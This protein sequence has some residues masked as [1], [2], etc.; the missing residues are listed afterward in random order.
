MTDLFSWTDIILTIS[1]ISISVG[2]SWLLKFILKK[3]RRPN[4]K[5][6]GF[7][8]LNTVLAFSIISSIALTTEDWFLTGL[9]V[10]PAYL[11]G[12]ESIRNKNN[13]AWQICLSAIIGIFT[14][15]FIF[16]LYKRNIS[17][18]ASI[19]RAE[20]SNM[21]N[22]AVDDRRQADTAPELRLERSDDLDNF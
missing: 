6:A 11:I 18:G 15:Y 5:K 17:G 12:R 1:A 7:V 22:N 13:Y 8:S 20:F 9:V 14:P 19:E 4:G 2:I 10:I 16:Y 21:P 3:V